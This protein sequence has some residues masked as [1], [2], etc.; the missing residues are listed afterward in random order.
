MPSSSNI[1]EGGVSNREITIIV[2]FICFSYLNLFIFQRQGEEE[3][4]GIKKIICSLDKR[5]EKNNPARIL[6]RKLYYF[7][8]QWKESIGR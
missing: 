3:K 6:N 5:A 7:S 8:S 4:S 2:E 1:N